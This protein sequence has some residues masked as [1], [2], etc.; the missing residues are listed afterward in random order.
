[1]YAVRHLAD[2]LSRSGCPFRKFSYFVGDDSKAT[3][4]FSRTCSLD[5]RIESKQVGLV[6]NLL[7]Y[8]CDTANFL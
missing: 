3:P 5:G 8:A 7:D 1:M 6:G 4:G 2:F